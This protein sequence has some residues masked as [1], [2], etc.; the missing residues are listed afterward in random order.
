MPAQTIKN[1]A[2]GDLPIG[3]DNF[4]GGDGLPDWMQFAITTAMFA[5][6]LWVLN[7]L[8]NPNL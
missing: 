6:L 7:L 8:F 5:T 2:K 3:P 4:R 1:V